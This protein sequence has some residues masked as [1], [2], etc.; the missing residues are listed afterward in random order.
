MLDSLYKSYEV[1]SEGTYVFLCDM[2]YDL[3]K[4]SKNAVD[5][6]DL[7]SEYMYGA[8]DIWAS[9]IHPDDREAYHKGIEEIFSGNSSG[10]DMQYRV[11]RNDGGYD[12]CTCRGIVIRDVDGTPDY[13][14]GTIRNHGSQSHVDTLTGLRNQYGFFDDLD[15]WI[16]RRAAAYVIIVGISKFSEI[17]EVYGY[18]FGNRVLQMFARKVF[19]TTGNT[20]TCYRIDGT[21]FAIINNSLIVDEVREKYNGFRDYFREVFQVDDKRILLEVNG[22]ALLMDHFDFDSQTVYACLNFAYG[23]SKTRRQGDLVLF[24]NDLNENNRH[25]LEKL[26]KI[27]SRQRRFS[28]GRTIHTE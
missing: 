25:R 11:C 5:T 4:W 15:S 1:V 10:H 16:K 13:F 9:H 3:S 28:D 8:G 26:H 19:E 23:E 6:Y 20:G 22:G 17:N 18:H 24:E 21:K 2:K 12:V 14:V 27:R 7:P